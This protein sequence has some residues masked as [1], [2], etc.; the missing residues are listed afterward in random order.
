MAVNGDWHQ[1]CGCVAGRLI[2]EA[3]TGDYSATCAPERRCSES[4][5]TRDDSSPL[6]AH[7]PGEAG[8]YSAGVGCPLRPSCLRYTISPTC[9]GSSWKTRCRQPFTP[10]G[11]IRTWMLLA[12]PPGLPSMEVAQEEPPVLGAEIRGQPRARS[13]KAGRA[14][15]SRVLRPRC[16]GMRNPRGSSA[17]RVSREVSAVGRRGIG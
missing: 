8:T 2:R 16:L 9:Q 17:S 11:D 7:G 15:R 13:P 12:C 3:W 10:L 14:R 5:Q 4:L 1:R 6:G